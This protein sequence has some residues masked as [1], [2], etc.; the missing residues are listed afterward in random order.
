MGIHPHL[1]TGFDVLIDHQ[2][3]TLVKRK[4]QAVEKGSSPDT[5]RRN[6]S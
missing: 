3:G 1:K 6:D 5:V 2:L 4:K